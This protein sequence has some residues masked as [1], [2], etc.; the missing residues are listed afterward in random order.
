MQKYFASQQPDEEVIM[1]VRKHWIALML[2]LSS[3][4]MIYLI[5][6]LI[7]VLVP[8]FA[9]K[10][11]SGFGYNFLVPLISLFFLFNTLYIFIEWLMYYLHIDIVTTEHLV[12]IG[13]KNLFSRK[14][15]TMDLENIQDVSATQEGMMQTFYNFGT[16]MVQTAGG[17]PNFA[18]EKVPNPYDVTQR[19]MELKE[20]CV[21]RKYGGNR[22]GR[23]PQS[24]I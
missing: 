4:A 2:P 7:V 20:E 17:L 1:V 16:V 8:I 23:S 24:H 6:I 9:P 11:F 13:Q 22:G 5:M 19:I 18:L 21:Q 3:G 14:I 15:A 12:D 10:V